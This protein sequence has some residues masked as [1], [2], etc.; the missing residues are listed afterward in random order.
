MKRQNFLNTFRRA[1]FLMTA[2]R[3]K[4][5]NIKGPIEFHGIISRENCYMRAEVMFISCNEEKL[6]MKARMKKAILASKLCN[7]VRWNIF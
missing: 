6:N 2:G 3:S 7:S 5:F 1:L 4:Y